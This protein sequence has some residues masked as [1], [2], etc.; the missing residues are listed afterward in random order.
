MSGPRSQRRPRA[1]KKKTGFRPGRS[2]AC[3]ARLY[4]FTG[5]AR[6]EFEPPAIRVAAC[7]IYEAIV[8]M[9]KSHPDLDVL[10]IEFVAMIQM[11][12]GSPLD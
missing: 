9:R 10:R 12:S 3:E 8:Y 2:G 11:V 1:I 6:G 4:Q 5:E 7:N